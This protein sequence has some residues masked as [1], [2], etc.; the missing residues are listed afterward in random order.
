MDLSFKIFRL[1]QY[2]RSSVIYAEFLICNWYSPKEQCLAEEG[3]QSLAGPNISMSNE[4]F[5]GE[6]RSFRQISDS[7]NL[8]VSQVCIT[9]ILP[10]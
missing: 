6:D 5:L 2:Q 3:N 7:L 10:L 8:S 9:N 1:H 4:S